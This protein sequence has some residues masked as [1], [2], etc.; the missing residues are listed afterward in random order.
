[1]G[2]YEEFLTA[3]K[4]SPAPPDYQLLLARIR[5]RARRQAWER[6]AALLGGTLLLLLALSPALSFNGLR[7]AEDGGLVAYVFE[8]EPLDGIVLDYVFQ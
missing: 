5:G 6:R 2:A 4:A 7:S 1:M 3:A 8:H